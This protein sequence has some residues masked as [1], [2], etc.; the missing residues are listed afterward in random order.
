MKK[1]CPIM[2][3]RYE[4][5]GYVECLGDRCALWNSIEHKCS[6]EII[7]YSLVRIDNDIKKLKQ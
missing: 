2:S 5:A 3:C 1:I 4:G 7:M 6:L